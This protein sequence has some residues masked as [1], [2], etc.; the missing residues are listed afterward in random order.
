MTVIDIDDFGK[1][2]VSH[3]NDIGDIVLRL[4]AQ[5]LSEIYPTDIIARTGS[6]EFTVVSTEALSDDEIKE[7]AER[8]MN[9]LA[10]AYS[11]K[12][13]A[14]GLTVSL[15]IAVQRIGE[16]EEQDTELLMQKSSKAL[17]SA[18]CSGKAKYCV[19]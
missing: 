16:N 13:Y 12:A 1:Y 19:F 4:T 3:D 7:T 11:S 17:Y 18:K 10:S 14:K 8:A 15:G 9:T 5:K 2:N 6:D